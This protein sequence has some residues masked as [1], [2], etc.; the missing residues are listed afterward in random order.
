MRIWPK[1]LTGYV[2]FSPALGVTEGCWKKNL[3]LQI[4]KK[5]KST[6][7]ISPHVHVFGLRKMMEKLMQTQG[8][9]ANATPEGPAGNLT[10]SHCASYHQTFLSGLGGGA[11]D[12]SEGH[13]T[14]EDAGQSEVGQLHLALTGHQNVLGFQVAVHHTIGVKECKTT[15]QLPH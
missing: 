10:C 8:H 14:A 13:V 2:C 7:A 3:Q 12:R 6:V 1:D 5:K 15:Q 9:H 11:Y 4:V